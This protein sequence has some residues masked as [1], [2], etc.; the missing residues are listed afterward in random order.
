MVDWQSES[1]VQVTLQAS[2]IFVG[3]G[4]RV[5]VGV[6]VGV[7]ATLHVLLIHATHPSLKAGPPLQSELR[8]QEELHAGGIL[9]DPPTQAVH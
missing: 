4:V 8:T 9:H 1:L 5:G 7:G 2:G 3:V 6:G